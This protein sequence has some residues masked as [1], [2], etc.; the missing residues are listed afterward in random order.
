[1]ENKFIN[2]HL[3][4]GA[5]FAVLGVFASFEYINGKELIEVLKIL[6]IGLLVPIVT[7][8]ITLIMLRNKHNDKNKVQ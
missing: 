2:I 6:G 4:G 1:M 5:F 3:I 8:S 7:S